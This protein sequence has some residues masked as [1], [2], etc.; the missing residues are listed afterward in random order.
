M[1]DQAPS[2]ERVDVSRRHPVKTG[3]PYLCHVTS[4]GAIHWH[5]RGLLQ[6]RSDQVICCQKP[7]TIRLSIVYR[8]F[9]STDSQALP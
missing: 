3:P 4:V 1:I 6:V 9:P 5:Y 2:E 8:L 7:D